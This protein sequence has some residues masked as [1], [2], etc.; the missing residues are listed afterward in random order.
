[1]QTLVL[2]NR[3]DDAWEG[4]RATTEEGAHLVDLVDKAVLRSAIGTGGG[5]IL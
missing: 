1:M 5:L 2:V 4:W 3:A